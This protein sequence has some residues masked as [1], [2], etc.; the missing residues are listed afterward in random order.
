TL[1]F[2]DV[3]M[4]IGGAA[5]SAA[6]GIKVQTFAL[7][8]L[9]IAASAAGRED[10]VAYGR[11]V[12]NTAVHRAV[13]VALLSIALVVTVSLVLSV[14]E[15]APFSHVLMETVSAFG[16]VGFS[17][18]LTQHLSIMGRL[19]IIVTMF[20][21]RLGPLTLVLALIARTKPHSLRYAPELVKIG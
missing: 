20:A 12:P 19:L 16:T 8:L 2:T 6:G 7:L 4:F 1:F 5:G 18:G 21:G 3:L 10:V 17:A 14:T 13:A 11:Q 15:T 9:A